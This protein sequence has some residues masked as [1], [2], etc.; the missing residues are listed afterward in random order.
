MKNNFNIGK[1]MNMLNKDDRSELLKRLSDAIK[2][3][4]QENILNSI[5]TD[6]MDNS[7]IRSLIDFLTQ[8]F[9]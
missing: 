5:H 6:A 7:Q 2:N 1:D 8:D 3:Y 4:S 9:N